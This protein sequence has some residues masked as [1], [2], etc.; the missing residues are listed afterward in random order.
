MAVVIGSWSPTAEWGSALLPLSLPSSCRL[1]SH[2][3]PGV[4]LTCLPSLW[5]ETPNV[6]AIFSLSHPSQGVQIAALSQAQY[7]HKKKRL[8]DMNQI[9]S[10]PSPSRYNH[11]P[12]KYHT[13]KL[14]IFPISYSPPTSITS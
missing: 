9:R 5:V 11:N 1:P 13:T 7:M 3:L 6:K 14:K 10:V 12:G 2:L 8:L 4:G